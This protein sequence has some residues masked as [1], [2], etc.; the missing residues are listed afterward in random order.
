MTKKMQATEIIKKI[1]QIEKH[2]PDELSLFA[3]NG[4]LM[5]IDES[6]G[7]RIV[8]TFDRI[9]CDG[10]DVGTT[11]DDEGYEYLRI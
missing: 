2:W 6:D 1:S 3:N 10:G 4:V 11:T 9:P 5:L 8:W 7:R